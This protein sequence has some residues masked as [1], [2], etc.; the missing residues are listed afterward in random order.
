MNGMGGIQDDHYVSYAE[1][2]DGDQDSADSNR[3][4]RE[5]AL[6]YN[7]SC[8]NDFGDNNFSSD[9]NRGFYDETPYVT[10]SECMA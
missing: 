5:A 7:R 10:C 6:G 8:D 2:D 1:N 3:A 9:D 4:N